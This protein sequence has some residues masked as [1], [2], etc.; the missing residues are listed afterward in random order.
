[1]V[2]LSSLKLS[3]N[4]CMSFAKNP[5]LLAKPFCLSLPMVDRYSKRELELAFSVDSVKPPEL[6]IS[7]LNMALE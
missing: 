3:L 6:V 4:I 5:F 2:T 1:M 7:P